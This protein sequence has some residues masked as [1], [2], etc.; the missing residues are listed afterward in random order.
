MDPAQITDEAALSAAVDQPVFLLFKHSLICP[1]SAAAFDEYRGYL[2]S[3]AEV[4]TAWL[5][6]IGQRPLSKAIEAQS[7]VTHQSPQALLFK[8]GEVVWHASHGAITQDSL[9]DAAG[10]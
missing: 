2:A 5:D 3:G 4:P 9:R 6:V 1:I 7:G 8:Q 10:A